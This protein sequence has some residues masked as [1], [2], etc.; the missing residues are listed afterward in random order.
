M[1]RPV[2]VE[3]LREQL[4]IPNYLWEYYV[5]WMHDAEEAHRL[6]TGD[7][8][9][10][11]GSRALDLTLPPVLR[12]VVRIISFDGD[13]LNGGIAQYFYNHT[14]REVLDTL[15]ALRAA[16]LNESADILT[17]AIDICRK[18]FQ[19]PAES[20][21]RWLDGPSGDNP[22]ISEL[23]NRRCNYESSERDFARLDS[24][25]RTRLDDCI[26]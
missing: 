9:S 14:P 6:A 22:E 12:Y 10:E 23:D 26:P 4:C 2:T 8:L 16:G 13:V 19:W 11:A 7:G 24:F 15:A 25:L 3:I 17:Q 20:D 5:E 18:R 21:D 1:P